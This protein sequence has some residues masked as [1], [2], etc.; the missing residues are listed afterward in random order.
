MRSSRR[1]LL[2]GGAL[3]TGVAATWFGRRRS[4]RPTVDAPI[5]QVVRYGDD[6]AQFAELSVPAGD[7]EA[8][9]A[10]IIHG[11]FWRQRFDLSLGRPLAATLPA[12]GWAALNIEYRRVGGGGGFPATLSD[13]SAA[14]DALADAD[15]ALDLRSVV[16]IGHSAGGHLA[17]WAATRRQPAVPV[18]AVVSQAGVLDLRAAARDQLGGGATQAFLG[19]SPD[20][21]PERYDAASPIEHLPLATPVL[22]VHGRAD[23]NVPFSQSETFV[24]AALAAGDEATLEAVDGDHFVVID[25]ASASWA[26]V[27]RWLDDHR[28]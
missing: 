28:P 8:P 2:A 17:A 26:T 10:V 16:T 20:E 9:V 15:A 23:G 11:G 18:T 5:P 3:V 13:V 24:G 27:L 21:V 4:S 12:R 19:G 7:G 22:C 6:P 14:I 25:P 1:G